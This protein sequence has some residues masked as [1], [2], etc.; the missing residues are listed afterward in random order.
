MVSPKTLPDDALQRRDALKVM[1]AAAV[2]ALL[3]ESAASQPASRP[4][5]VFIMADDLGYADLS[6]YGRRDYATPEIDRLAREGLIMTQ[7]YSNS[8]VCSPTRIALMTGRYHQRLRGG[9][10]E[11]IKWPDPE[12]GLPPA[13]PTLPFLLRT[14]G[15]STA[16]VGK[17]HMGWPPQFG[18]LRSGYDRFFG[19]VAGAA[20]YVSHRPNLPDREGEIAL[21]EGDEPVRRTGYMTDILADHALSELRTAAASRKPFL[22]SLHFNAPHWPW[23][24][25]GDPAIPR[26]TRDLWHRDGGSLKTY[27]KMVLAMDAAVGRVMAELE[28]LGLAGNTIVIFTSDNGGE[29]FSDMWPLRGSK[30]ELLEGGIRV[31]QIVRWPGRIRAGTESRQVMATMDWLPTLLAAAATEPDEAFPPDGVNLLDVLTGAAPPRPR[32]LF[33]RFRENGQAAVRDG[34]WKYLRIEGQEFLFDIPQ[35]PRER[36]DLKA[37]SPAV[38]DRL[39]SEYESWAETM[40]P[41]PASE[42]AAPTG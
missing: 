33:W 41:Y 5:M 9:L 37:A 11:P 27:G 1:G 42:A 2:A 26:T 3:P 24:A 40:L 36:T 7:A 20:D 30:G 21:Y 19:I 16:L 12:L 18:P 10:E 31:P 32:K 25:P 39:R 6:C 13:H 17:W 8:A 29:R 14:S 15:Y 22:L 38:F 4:N 23:Q 35:D 28:A 34:D